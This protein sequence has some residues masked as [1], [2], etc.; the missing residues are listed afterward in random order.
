M[1]VDDKYFRVIS[2][3]SIFQPWDRSGAGLILPQTRQ[4]GLVIGCF[5]LFWLHFVLTGFLHPGIEL[6]FLPHFS[7]KVS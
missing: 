5:A 4:K 6:G 2:C 3:F 7:S 1:V